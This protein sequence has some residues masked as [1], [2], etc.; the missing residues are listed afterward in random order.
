VKSKPAKVQTVK[1]PK[2]LYTC[3]TDSKVIDVK[4]PTPLLDQEQRQIV[5]PDGKPMFNPPVK[6]LR[7][8]RGYPVCS[9]DGKPVY[10][11]KNDMGYDE[12]GKKIAV[13]KVKVPKATPISITR[14]TFTVDGMIGKAEMNYTI[15]DLK[16]IYLYAPGIGIAVVSNEPFPGAAAQKDAFKGSSLVVKVDD[17]RLELASDKQILTKN[18]KGAPAYVLMDR[19][20]DHRLPSKF[21]AVGYGRLRVWPYEWP[22]S[23]ENAVLKGIIKPPP[24]PRNLR[25]VMLLP[26]CQPGQMRRPLAKA[27]LPGEPIP[28]QPCVPITKTL[29]AEQAAARAK[30]SQKEADTD[31][32][33]DAVTKSAP[34]A[35]ATAPPTDAA[36]PPPADT[37]AANP[38][39]PATPPPASVPAATD[40]AP[41]VP[42]APAASA[43]APAPPPAAVPPPPHG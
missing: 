21:P 10:Q 1:V 25:P 11:T 6:Q 12:K 5:D 41:A 35:G 42:A 33:S 30:A 40:T 27:P 9:A 37:S 19:D 32:P 17:H 20:P 3:P 34:E 31:V 15:P 4:E 2:K 22:G 8:K 16:Y 38:S 43:P 39:A 26:S 7:D 36:V 29:Q 13:P 14:G 24:T 18:P 23:K 28:D